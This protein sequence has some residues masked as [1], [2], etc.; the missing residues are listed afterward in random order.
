MLVQALAAEAGQCCSQTQLPCS[1]PEAVTVVMDRQGRDGREQR[2]GCVCPFPAASPT[3]K[4]FIP[5]TSAMG[6]S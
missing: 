1:K 6:L 2:G 3:A 4:V 5:V